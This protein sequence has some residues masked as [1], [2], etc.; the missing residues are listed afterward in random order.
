MFTLEPA[1]ISGK[2]KPAWKPRRNVICPS[3]T[4]NGSDVSPPAGGMDHFLHIDD[5]SA[6]DLRAMLRNAAVAKTAFYNR[7]NSFKPFQGWT[8]AMIF[9]KPSART[10]VSFETV[11]RMLLSTVYLTLLVQI[12][13]ACR[14]SANK[15]EPRIDFVLFR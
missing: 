2:R 6:N 10:R 13:Y 8:M 9:T 11:R 15:N 1:R 7:D 14:A 4:Y 5:F 3:G 12:L